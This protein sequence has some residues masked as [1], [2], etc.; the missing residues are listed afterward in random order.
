[1]VTLVLVVV[2]VVAAGAA[3][4]NAERAAKTR[5]VTRSREKEEDQV[6]PR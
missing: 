6:L 1:M 3:T 4:V 2:V 5:G